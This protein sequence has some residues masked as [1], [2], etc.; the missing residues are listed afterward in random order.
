MQEIEV[1]EHHINRGVPEEESQCPIA[2]AIKGE[3]GT[4]NVAVG[5]DGKVC[6]DNEWHTPKN[7]DEVRAFVYQFDYGHGNPADRVGPFIVKL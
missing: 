7:L 6:I 3:I 5:P 1:T 4:H 2:L